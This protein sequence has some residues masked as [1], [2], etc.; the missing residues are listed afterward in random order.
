MIEQYLKSPFY[1]IMGH[2][3]EALQY[4]TAIY[5]S[6]YTKIENDT[7]V[8]EDYVYVTIIWMVALFLPIFGGKNRKCAVTFIS[9][10]ILYSLQDKIKFAIQENATEDSPFFQTVSTHINN[11]SDAQI[12]VVCLV[13]SL[14][15]AS[16]FN[17]IMYL[18]TFA[19]YVIIVICISIFY[20][21][22]IN[23]A[24]SK[25]P[26][27]YQKHVGYLKNPIVAIIILYLAYYMVR[28]ILITVI[29]SLIGTLLSG[30]LFEVTFNK[31]SVVIR[32]FLSDLRK[33]TV[34]RDEI[35]F[36]WVLISLLMI[37]FQQNIVNRFSKGKKQYIRQ[38]IVTAPKQRRFWYR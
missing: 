36:Y 5:L 13:F 19:I 32:G 10:A 21:D 24:V 28:D 38:Y 37:S 34:E 9:T 25:V 7:A 30:I 14:V 27:E 31:K 22:E 29:F 35:F 1:F 26:A 8:L 18:V 17:S 16:V 33:G 4:I 23:K 6:H 3:A 15:I 12:F 11:F 2:V 20:K